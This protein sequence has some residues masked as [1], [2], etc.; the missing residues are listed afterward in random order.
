MVEKTF[1]VGDR[2]WL[3]LNKERLQGP[4]KKIKALQYGPFEVL[5]K[6]GD[7][8]YRLS[9]PPSMC[10]YSIVNVEN[11]KLYELSML[12]Q[13]SEQVLTSVEDLAPKAQA[14]LSK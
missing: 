2:V 14:K 1:K 4:S 10:I 9:L 5:E 8:A 11:L 3:H 13:E 7:N 6:I 12:D